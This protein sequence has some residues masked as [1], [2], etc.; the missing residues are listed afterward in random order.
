MKPTKPTDM[1][2]TDPTVLKDIQN[3]IT[4]KEELGRYLLN[5]FPA[6]ALANDLAEAI[7]TQQK[8]KPI[9]MSIDEFNAHFRLRGYRFQ[10]GQLIKEN[11]GHYSKKV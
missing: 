9:V 5:H 10:D 1:L 8:N 7:L 6:T 4:T 2:I 11:R 3:G